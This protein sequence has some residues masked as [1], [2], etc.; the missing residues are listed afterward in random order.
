MSDQP[1]ETDATPTPSPE[2]TLPEDPGPSFEDLS[3]AQALGRF[4][5][6]P[7]RTARA[8]LLVTAPVPRG[9]G[10]RRSLPALLTVPTH[11]TAEH[12]AWRQH[13]D[14]ERPAA[15][16]LFGVVGALVMLWMGNLV[17]I[18][19]V[20]AE[21]VELG[22]RSPAAYL[23]FL[24][25][26][27]AF[28]LGAELY[29]RQIDRDFVPRAARM[30]DAPTA[31]L[32]WVWLFPAAFAGIL[33]AVFNSENTFTG[34][35]VVAWLAAAALTALAFMPRDW[36]AGA[37]VQRW[38]QGVTRFPAQQPA[39]FAALLLITLFGAYFRLQSLDAMPP[40]MT[41]DHIEKL[42]NAQGVVD[43]QY[44]VFFR[45]NGGRE[46]FQMYA[47]AW[48]AQLVPGLAVDFWT[49]KLIAALEAIL[50]IPLMWG[51]G[52]AFV[53]VDRDPRL[54]NALGLTAALAMAVGYWHVA[55]ARVSLRIILTPLVAAALLIFLVR[56]MRH[57]RR[58]DFVAAG[59]VLGFGLY[60]YQAVR[61][62]PLVVIAAGIIGVFFQA[63]GWPLRRRVFFN[64]VALVI[65]AFSAFV[66]LFVFSAEYPNDFWRRSAGRLLGDELIQVELE[67]GEVVTREAT[68]EERAAAFSANIGILGRNVFD[69]LLMF[70]YRGDVIYLH[71]AP[72]YP[73]MV[74]LM[75][76]LLIGGLLLWMGRF[77]R[78]RDPA[79]L[80]VV[81]ALFIMLLPS[82][83][84]IANPGEN[85][86]HTR[87]SGAMPSAYLLAG[88][89]LAVTATLI[90]RLMPPRVGLAA[91][92][93]VVA[94]IGLLNYSA[95]AHRL[96]V[97][98]RE[99]YIESWKPL[100]DGGRVLRG[101]AE[102]DGTYGNAFML[103]YP[104]WW[105]YRVVANEAG[106]PAGYWRNGDIALNRLPDLIKQAYQR[107]P[108]DLDH[109]DPARDLLI[110]YSE[111]HV[112]ASAQLREWFPE[113]RETLLPTYKEGVS[114]YV[115]RVPALG[116]EG[117]I[118]WL[119]A[120]EAW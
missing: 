31:G 69:V 94:V 87:T 8:M 66:P 42:L 35:G 110:L 113:G 67:N 44:D 117:L 60:T 99:D 85:P 65:V 84:S 49:M 14:A 64:Y 59:L 9:L 38:W 114:F 100:S 28:I 120:R 96:L 58:Q 26:A 18:G 7:A 43:G 20:D 106:M 16:R 74:P 89:S 90:R 3:L 112:E 24:A 53:G 36:Q 12:P 22:S 29:A 45:N 72:N 23:P 5:R 19:S 2:S 104:H 83:L 32:R 13:L 50:T 54:A 48:V 86:S 61:M 108:A 116:A 105:D 4:F 78:L 37:A 21:T 41:S 46:G 103:A 17:L 93:G 56:A 111:D 1:H 27:L 97:T 115:Y 34:V 102:S 15:L 76:A 70:N 98:H 88:F 63:R 33:T 119:T 75:A 68:F 107:D 92:V 10:T 25:L 40:E 77:V 57:N 80:V 101:F 39:V 82:A 62:L 109:L 55:V 118:A 73:A 51:L 47:I 6:A 71:N 91:A 52:R 30:T 95:A 11:Q 79:E 81:L